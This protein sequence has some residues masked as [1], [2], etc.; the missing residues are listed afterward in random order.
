[1]TVKKLFP[2]VILTLVIRTEVL[3]IS[4]T[5]IVCSHFEVHLPVEDEILLTGLGHWICLISSGNGWIQ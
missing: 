3:S 5:P 1:M 4:N 2:M